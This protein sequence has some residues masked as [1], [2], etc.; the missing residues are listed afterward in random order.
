MLNMDIFWKIKL[1][2]PE[3]SE[4]QIKVLILYSCGSDSDTISDILKCSKNA[5]K[6]ALRRIKENLNVEKLDTV[7]AIYHSRSSTAMMASDEFLQE[8]SVIMSK[9]KPR[10]D[11]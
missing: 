2:F 5:V 6:M 10:G 11:F 4:L 3:L 8:F 9:R 7:R 1:M